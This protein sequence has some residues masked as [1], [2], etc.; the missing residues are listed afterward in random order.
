MIHKAVNEKALHE[1]E[2]ILFIEAM[3]FVGNTSDEVCGLRGIPFDV[4][5]GGCGERLWVR[6]S[7]R[8]QSWET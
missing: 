5:D 7:P 6:V 1:P 4:L 8:R 2:T 3:L